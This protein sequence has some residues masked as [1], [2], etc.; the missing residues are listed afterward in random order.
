M[1]NATVNTETT[2]VTTG[3]T[4]TLS[5][6]E[7]QVLTALLYST[8]WGPQ[9]GPRRHLGAVSDTLQM[10]GVVADSAAQD[11]GVVLNGKVEVTDGEDESQ[12]YPW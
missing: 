8:V 1:A 7:A 2:I 5:E 10:A 3:Y 11:S 12:G 4:L 6:E 9:S